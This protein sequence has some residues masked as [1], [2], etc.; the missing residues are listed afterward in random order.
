MRPLGPR[1]EAGLEDIFDLCCAAVALFFWSRIWM[2]AVECF[3]WA[4]CC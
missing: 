3:I 1:G 4:S 2:A